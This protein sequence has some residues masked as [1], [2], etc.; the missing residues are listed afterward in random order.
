MRGTFTFLFALIL[1]SPAFCENCPE[2]NIQVFPASNPWHW[3]V[4][5][6]AVHSDSAAYVNSIGASANIHPDF[7]NGNNGIPYTVV[8]GGQPVSINIKTYPAESDKGPFPIPLNAQIEGGGVGDAHVISVDVKNKKLYELYQGKRSGSGWDCSGA[9]KW[10]LDSNNLRKEGWTSTDAAGLPVFPGLVKYYEIA[11]NSVDHPFRFTVKTSRRRYVYPATHYASKNTSA[12]VPSMGQRA[13]LKK[14][15][16]ISGLGKQAQVIAAAMKKYG[17]ILADNG[18]NWFISGAPDDRWNMSD[19]A[20]L[21]AI[22]GSNME[23]VVETRSA[24]SGSLAVRAA[25]PLEK[26][27]AYGEP[28]IPGKNKVKFRSAPNGEVFFE[29]FKAEKRDKESGAEIIK[30]KSKPLCKFSIAIGEISWDLKEDS[31]EAVP[32]GDYDIFVSD[33]K[34]NEKLITITAAQ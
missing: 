5:G 20:G 12:S 9:A 26:M 1:I 22:K 21:K 27:C 34:K 32:A 23:F 3:D 6:L 17:I 33:R 7:G 2:V 19:L 28:F 25:N 4:S 16:N 10:D 11:K 8:D 24:P 13:R 30:P 31:G 29:I 14:D 18:S 15:F